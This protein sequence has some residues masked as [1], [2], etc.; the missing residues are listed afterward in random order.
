MNEGAIID[1]LLDSLQPARASGHQ[2][3]LVDGGSEDDTLARAGGKVDLLLQNRASR[4]RQMNRGARESSG[5]WLWFLHADSSLLRIPR[6][7]DRSFQRI[8]TGHSK[9]T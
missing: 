8:V 3:V 9:R 2:V 4:A 6:Q 7:R 5:Q 1:G